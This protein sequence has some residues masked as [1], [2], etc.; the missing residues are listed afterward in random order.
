VWWG[1]GGGCRYRKPLG[2]KSIALFWEVAVEGGK[3][4]EGCWKLG[5]RDARDAKGNGTNTSLPLEPGRWSGE[6]FV[7]LFKKMPPPARSRVSLTSMDVSE[8]CDSGEMD[9]DVESSLMSRR[10]SFVRPCRLW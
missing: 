9:G 6:H 1:L 7:L 4:A 10:S 5:P 3:K 2:G 8:L